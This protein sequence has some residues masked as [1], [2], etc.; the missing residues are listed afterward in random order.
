LLIPVEKRTPLLVRFGY[1]FHTVTLSINKK[2]I[3]MMQGAIKNSSCYHVI[4]KDLAP[5][6]E[7]FVGYDDDGNA[8]AYMGAALWKT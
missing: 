5:L 8:F 6:L 7:G 2:M 3:R 1:L 4:A